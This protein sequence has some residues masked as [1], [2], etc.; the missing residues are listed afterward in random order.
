VADLGHWLQQ[1]HPLAGRVPPTTDA[2]SKCKSCHSP[3]LPLSSSRPTTTAAAAAAA[4]AAVAVAAAEGAAVA[5]P[6]PTSTQEA[7]MAAWHVGKD[8]LHQ[9]VLWGMPTLAAL[10]I[11]VLGSL[12]GALPF[13]ELVAQGEYICPERTLSSTTLGCTSSGRGESEQELSIK[14][15]GGLLHLVSLSPQ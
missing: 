2:S 13:A 7:H 14:Q 9:C 12:P 4:A 8:L 10:L 15:L 3:H 6:P 1:H 11:R 5:A